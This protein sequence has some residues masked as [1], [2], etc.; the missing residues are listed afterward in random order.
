MSTAF[1]IEEARAFSSFIIFWAK[2]SHE[3]IEICRLGF[4]GN[5]N[6]ASSTNNWCQNIFEFCS[7]ISINITSN[8][9]PVFSKMLCKFLVRPKDGAP[10]IFFSFAMS[11]DEPTCLFY[12]LSIPETHHRIK[13]EILALLPS[14]MKCSSNCSQDLQDI[15]L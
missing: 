3:K 13:W 10:D 7:L 1:Q 8:I 14:C 9:F 15:F 4:R 5:K 2:A 6:F 12:P 11:K